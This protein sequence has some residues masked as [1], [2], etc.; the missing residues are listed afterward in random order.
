MG[1][2]IEYQIGNLHIEILKNKIANFGKES[3][4]LNFEQISPLSIV[5]GKGVSIPDFP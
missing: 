4:G 1:R 2:D 5:K 3:A